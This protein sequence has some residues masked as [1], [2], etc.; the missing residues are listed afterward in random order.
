MLQVFCNSQVVILADFLQKGTTTTSAYYAYFISKCHEANMIIL[1][2][3]A[4][5]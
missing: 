2:P 1:F 4:V 5:K 3:N